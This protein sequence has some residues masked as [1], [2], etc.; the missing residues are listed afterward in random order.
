MALDTVADIVRAGADLLVAGNA[1][2]GRG[3]AKQNARELLD[4][5]RDTTLTAPETITMAND[6]GFR[7]HRVPT[8]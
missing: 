3:D 4:A 5:A 2:F 8:R 7:P 1:V 6:L